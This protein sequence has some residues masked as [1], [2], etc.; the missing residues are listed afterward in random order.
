ML[1]WPTWETIGL[2]AG[3][4][5]PLWD[6]PLIVQVLRR[7]SSA[8]ISVMWA[9][10]I[11]LSSVLMAPSAFVSGDKAAMGFNAVNVV[12]LTIVLIVVLKYR[13]AKA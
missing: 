5:L 7:K 10:G 11:W 12:M 6:I 4:M 9:V 3:V 8:D 1:H 2:W 13:K